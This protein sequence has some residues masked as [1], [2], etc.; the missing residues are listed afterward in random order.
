[1]NAFTYLTGII[2]NWSKW[3]LQLEEDIIEGQ[4][5]LARKSQEQQESSQPTNERSKDQ[6]QSGT[7]EV[8]GDAWALYSF[9]EFDRSL[10]G[11]LGVLHSAKSH[12]RG[13]AVLNAH[14]RQP[15]NNMDLE[16]TIK[17]STDVDAYELLEECLNIARERCQDA[18][19][20]FLQ[21]GICSDQI[22]Q[23]RREL[24]ET[25]RLARTE[26]EKYNVDERDAADLTK[27]LRQLATDTVAGQE[28]LALMKESR[29][30][31]ALENGYFQLGKRIGE[32][33][34]G[35]V[36]EGRNM[37]NSKPVAIKF[38]SRRQKKL[39]LRCV[40]T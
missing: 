29:R 5:E 22:S 28:K 4:I 35:T 15:E 31:L 30:T 19:E 24:D 6:Q 39:P 36:Y 16:A 32:G 33:A 2:P 25:Y 8:Y 12:D 1:M 26:R 9:S 7:A 14:S 11:S 13:R 37:V 34:N 27:I 20:S 23:I 18:V 17:A 3:L 38:V 10:N 40:C 21:Y